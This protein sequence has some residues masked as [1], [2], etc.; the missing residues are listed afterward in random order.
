MLERILFHTQCANFSLSATF[1]MII[2]TLKKNTFKN[3]EIKR[4]ITKKS[5]TFTLLN[6]FFNSRQ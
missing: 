1:I 3:V 2:L 6:G 4:T 5:W